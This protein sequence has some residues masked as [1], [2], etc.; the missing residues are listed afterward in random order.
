MLTLSEENRKKNASAQ[1]ILVNSVLEYSS[2]Q[3]VNSTDRL[4]ME[5][6]CATANLGIVKVKNIEGEIWIK[7]K[8]K[9]NAERWLLS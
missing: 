8:S 9:E 5:I 7:L 3:R 1:E 6:V 4:T 2:W